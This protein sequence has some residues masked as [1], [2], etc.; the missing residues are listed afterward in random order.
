MQMEPARQTVC[1]ILPLRRAAH[2]Q[3]LHVANAFREA[4][5]MPMLSGIATRA[6][7][8]SANPGFTQHG[9]HAPLAAQAMKR[10][11]WDGRGN[12]FAAL[13]VGSGA[14]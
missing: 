10:A 9:A 4:R 3:L 12:A 6:Q 1:A 7:F 11:A 13:A 14:S 2:L 8:A 5:R